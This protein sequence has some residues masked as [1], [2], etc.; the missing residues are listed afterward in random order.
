MDKKDKKNQGFTLIEVAI[1]L[2]IA[3]IILVPMLAAYSIFIEKKKIAEIDESKSVIASALSKYVIRYG[4]YPRPA[5][6]NV[7]I[8]NP[9]FGQE[10]TIASIVGCNTLGAAA[11]SVPACMAPGQR[12]VIAGAPTPDNIYVGVVPF[13]TLG[14][15]Y[16]YA[17]DFKKN[18]ITY[19][20]TEYLT[21]T[22][23]NFS[24]ANG[25]I[26]VFRMDAEP[27]A[28]TPASDV[29]PANSVHYVL[30]VH[31]ENE[32]GASNIN[33]IIT[34]ACDA[35]Q[36]RDADNC[37]RDGSFSKGMYRKPDGSWTAETMSRGAGAQYFDDIVTYANVATANIWV[38]SVGGTD[39]VSRNNGDVR[40]G[41]SMADPRAKIDVDGDVRADRVQTNDICTLTS[42]PLTTFNPRVIGGTPVAGGAGIK[43]SG[44]R[45]MTG[46][47]QANEECSPDTRFSNPAAIAPC[48]AGLRAYGVSSTGAL[49]CR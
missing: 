49:L 13:A 19:A 10:A 41:L 34:V 2:V 31:G 48:G 26:G 42:C 43:C 20:V 33:G 45:A 25:V 39:I 6:P 30:I 1:A 36:G 37:N 35:T 12:D 3:G 18:K 17:L 47:A 38:Q 22:G 32:M 9:N 29:A 21:R 24:D 28:A 15:P 5:H 46:I 27:P 7:P 40:V 11:T 23:V 4:R 44:D 14:I 8:G 16:R